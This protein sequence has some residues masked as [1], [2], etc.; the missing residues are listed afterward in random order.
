MS[1]NAHCPHQAQIIFRVLGEHERVHEVGGREAQTLFCLHQ[2]GM[3]GVT[4]QE[5]SSWALRLSA[6]VHK[7]RHIYGLD[8]ITRREPNH[9]SG[10]HARYVLLD[11]VEILS[12]IPVEKS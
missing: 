12:I 9:D 4:A 6:Y 10:H 5:L 11:A 1:I 8:I 7:L 3:N 2:A